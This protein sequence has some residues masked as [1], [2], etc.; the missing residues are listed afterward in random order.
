MS[1]F[2]VDRHQLDLGRLHHECERNFRRLAK[3]PLD[4]LSLAT[5]LQI[6]FK[7][8]AAGSVKFEVIEV[9]RYTS[10][11]AIVANG[12]GLQWLPEINLKARSYRDA[13]MFEVIEWCSDRTIPW[14]LSESKGMQARDEKWQWNLFLSELLIHS[15]Q[16]GTVIIETPQ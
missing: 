14:T 16:H 9:T 11:L 3:L 6:Q 12:R 2:R 13:K 8:L 15:L 4:T 7:G 10:T 1:F 5:S